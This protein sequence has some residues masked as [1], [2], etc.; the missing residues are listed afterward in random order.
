ML[1][2][3]SVFIFFGFLFAGCAMPKFENNT[4]EEYN[5]HMKSADGFLI[6]KKY[7]ESRI[8]ITKALKIGQN[9]SD[10]NLIVEAK[11]ALANIYIFE[12]NFAESER[13][14]VEAKQICERDSSCDGSLLGSIFYDM[15]WLYAY[16]TKNIS[17][18]EQTAEEVIKFRS[19]LGK[20]KT[21]KARLMEYAGIMTHSG[22]KV[23][24]I[25]LAERAEEF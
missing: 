24:A 10:V 18:A 2:K 21:L 13:N 6:K 3:V 4:I 15:I 19:R 25:R 7:K 11:Q 5:R 22:F 23:E 1:K 12:D 20:D 14:L 16:H 17:K 9:N 8:S